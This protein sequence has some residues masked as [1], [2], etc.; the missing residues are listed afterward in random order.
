MVGELCG[1][2]QAGARKWT[3]NNLAFM[4]MALVAKFTFVMNGEG[5]LDYG[6]VHDQVTHPVWGILPRHLSSIH[7]CALLLLRL[8]RLRLLYAY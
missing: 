6:T 1:F 5:F 4:F 7:M 2:P 3:L 8:L